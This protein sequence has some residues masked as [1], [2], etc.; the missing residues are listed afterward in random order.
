M[1]QTQTNVLIFPTTPLWGTTQTAH[2]HYFPNPRLQLVCY[3]LCTA[4]CK[5]WV[6]F[7]R[8]E[9]IC[10]NVSGGGWPR[11]PPLSH[12]MA[13]LSTF[14]LSCSWDNC[15]LIGRQEMKTVSTLSGIIS[16][17]SNLPSSRRSSFISAGKLRLGQQR[18]SFEEQLAKWGEEGAQHT[19]LPPTATTHSAKRCTPCVSREY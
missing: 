18:R 13:I 5:T 10:A 17:S 2:R 15:G 14:L 4:N 1:N 6:L 8:T 9:Q 3:S 16:F 19:V 11:E 12:S 7:I